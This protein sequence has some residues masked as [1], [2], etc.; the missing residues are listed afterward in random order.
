M[1]KLCEERGIQTREGRLL[2]CVMGAE[3]SC[4]QN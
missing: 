3:D 2:G 1:D 4:F